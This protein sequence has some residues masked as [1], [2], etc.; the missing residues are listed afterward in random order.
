MTACIAASAASKS[1]VYK[2]AVF[3]HSLSSSVA[4]SDAVIIVLRDDAPGE[5]ED[6]LRLNDLLPKAAPRAFLFIC[7]NDASDAISVA[8]RRSH[9]EAV[10]RLRGRCV[11][12]ISESNGRQEL[13]ETTSSLLQR[14]DSMRRGRKAV[15]QGL[16]VAALSVTA[17]LVGFLALNLGEGEK[18]SSRRGK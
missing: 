3:N 4:E 12:Y 13:D 11:K 17:A 2:L 6:A 1:V 8:R 7:G 18:K 15:I 14:L 16:C 9:V 5:L 10:G